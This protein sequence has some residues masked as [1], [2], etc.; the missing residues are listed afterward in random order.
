MESER[1][2][3]RLNWKSSLTLKGRNLPY[4]TIRIDHS[5][6]IHLTNQILKNETSGMEEGD[7]SSTLVL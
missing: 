2:I 3:I 6:K 7:T 4:N 1:L 5:T